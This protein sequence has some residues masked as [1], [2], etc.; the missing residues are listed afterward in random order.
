MLY[1][2]RLCYVFLDVSVFKVFDLFKMVLELWAPP[3]LTTQCVREK[4]DEWIVKHPNTPPRERFLQ[5]YIS[6]CWPVL[7]HLKT[8]FVIDLDSESEPV[9]ESETV[10]M[11]PICHCA[12]NFGTERL[13]CNHQ[14]H[15][16]CIHRWLQRASTCPLCRANL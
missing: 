16:M 11:C 9:S 15:T 1:I 12:L 2:Y 3:N 8:K 5:E 13:A 14:F 4:V 10:S 6:S 7:W